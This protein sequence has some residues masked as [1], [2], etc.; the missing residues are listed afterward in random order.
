MTGFKGQ[1]GTK[2]T[3]VSNPVP[4]EQIEAEAAAYLRDLDMPNLPANKEGTLAE[5]QQQIPSASIS[6]EEMGIVGKGLDYAGRGLDYAG[7]L[8]RTGLAQVAGMAQDVAQGKNP[9]NEPQVVSEADVQA[10]FKGKAPSSEEYLRRLGVP[11]GGSIKAGGFTIT[12]RDVVGL[13]G[14]ITTDPL[15]SLVKLAKSSPYLRKLIN[16]E[17]KTGLANKA[18]EAL[19]EAIYKSA[20]PKKAQAAVDAIQQ[21]IPNTAYNGEALPWLSKNFAQKVDDVSSVMGKLRQGLYDRADELKVMIDPAAKG[22]TSKADEVLARMKRDRGLAPSVQKLEELLQRYKEGGPVSVD[23]LSEWKTNLY[24]AL[25]ESAFAN[26]KLRGFAKQ[27]KVALA[28][29]FRDAIAKAANGAEKGLGDSINAINAN[30][31]ILL[32]ATKPLE[33]ASQATGG[34]LG[35][36]VDGAIAAGGAL[37]GGVMGAATGY[38]GKKAFDLATGATARTIAGKALMEAGKHDLMSR[39]AR[40]ST[41]AIARGRRASPLQPDPAQDEAAAYLQDIEE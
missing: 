8:T 32:S 16:A 33:R 38:A 6:Q 12:G 41:A 39:L 27:F 18:T 36:V 35:H 22:I 29:D 11:E 14:D 17:S 3:Q 7:G 34:K 5:V 4:N 25:P 2:P 37:A 26:G 23:I 1:P 10:A 9:L 28:G 24:D 19:G 13:A 30:W 31:G 21:G 20:I 40:Q 15:T